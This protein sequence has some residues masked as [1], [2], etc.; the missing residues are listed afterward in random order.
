MRGNKLLRLEPDCAAARILSR[1][2]ARRMLAPFL[3]GPRGLSEAA[4]ASGVSRQTMRYWV[5]K[6]ETHGLLERLQ[7]SQR[8]RWQAVASALLIPF[9]ASA[10]S[11]L[12][13]WVEQRLQADYEAF[14]R[15]AARH[16]EEA[17]L[18]H[19]LFYVDEDGQIMT[20]PADEEGRLGLESSFI[21]GFS[22]AIELSGSDAAELH[23]DL[24]RLWERY[25]A[26]RGSGIRLR[27]YAYIVKEP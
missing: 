3:A 14:L 6:F 11:G 5:R 7:V 17:G 21:N 20:R 12:L 1:E 8:P 19:I 25:R 18:D 15:D 16:Y 23:R 4:R 13:E 10:S 2:K 27:V 26:K 22:G 9:A 24:A